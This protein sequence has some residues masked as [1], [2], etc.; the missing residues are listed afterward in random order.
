MQATDELVVSIWDYD[1]LGKHD[2]LGEYRFG[3]AEFQVPNDRWWRLRS[4]PAR[5]DRIDGEV[6][7]RIFPSS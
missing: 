4:R 3:Y 6:Q 5:H 2:F 1:R 7:V